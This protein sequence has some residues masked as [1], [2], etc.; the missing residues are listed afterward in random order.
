[1][2]D[3]KKK[4]FEH[5]GRPTWWR[6]IKSV[7]AAFLG[8]QTKKNWEEDAG[9]SSPMRFIVVGLILGLGFFVLLFLFV[10]VVSQFINV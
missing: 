6:A 9:S 2:T 5:T 3:S 1:M 7:L 4:E 8:V 10:W